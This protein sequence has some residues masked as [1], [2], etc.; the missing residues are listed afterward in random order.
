MTDKEI[1]NEAEQY[2]DTVDGYDVK[3]YS[4]SDIE[5]AYITGH[6]KGFQR[7]IKAQINFTTVSDAPLMQNEQL[8]H[9]TEII[10]NLLEWWGIYGVESPRYQH[11]CNEAESFLKEV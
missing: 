1:E 11:L 3:T 6:K 4:I 9:A 2:A 10:R 8:E 7:G 5:Q